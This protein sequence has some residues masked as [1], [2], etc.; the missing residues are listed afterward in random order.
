M[1]V[2]RGCEVDHWRDSYLGLSHAQAFLHFNEV[3]EAGQQMFDG[4]PI[5]GIPKKFQVDFTK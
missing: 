4:R 2:Y 3:K 5:I 1:I